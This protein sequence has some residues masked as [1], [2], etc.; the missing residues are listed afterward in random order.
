VV[1]AR[2]TWDANATA[3]AFKAGPPQGHRAATLLAQAPE[4]KLDSGHAHPD[5][6]SFIIYGGGRTLAADTGY[7]G[8]PAARQ[9]NTITVGGIGQGREGRHDVWRDMPHDRLDAIRIVEARLSPLRATIVADAEAAYPPEAGLKRFRRTFSF[10]A[11]GA[12]T[13]TD[14]VR[15]EKA[16]RVQFYLHADGRF[17]IGPDGRRASARPDPASDVRL[18]AVVSGPVGAHV[19]A[20]VTEVLAPGPPGSIEKGRLEPRGH[21]LVIESPAPA[22]RHRFEV[23][24]DVVKAPVRMGRKEPTRR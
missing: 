14:D 10:Q 5:A 2:T 18:D 21:E 9:H 6:A 23:L 7:S 16:V 12:F 22:T 19:R 1:F 17:A 3:F 20:G 8:T 24:L 11:P 4:A 13:V 15:T